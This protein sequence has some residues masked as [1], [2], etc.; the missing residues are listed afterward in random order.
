MY[1]IG[2]NLECLREPENQC[3]EHAALVYLKK[4]NQ[5][6]ETIGHIPDAFIK[7][8]DGLMSQVS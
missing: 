3:K 4:T 6:M 5:R 2:E 8:V 7:L 1:T